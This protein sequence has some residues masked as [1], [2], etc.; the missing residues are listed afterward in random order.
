MLIKSRIYLYVFLIGAVLYSTLEVA[1]RG[2]THW[3]MFL[4]GGVIFLLIYLIN[5]YLR[6]NSLTVRCL[7]S[8][9]IITTGELI[10]GIVVNIVLN[11]N[12][13]DY[14]N[15][16]FNFLGQICLV[17]TAAWFIVSI[18]ACLLSVFIYNKLDKK[19]NTDII[20]H[21]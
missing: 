9:L 16:P 8:T 14:S 20:A 13:W 10:A 12:V 7:L 21:F 2:Y 4:A 15:Q 3:T 1:F 19:H 6:T 17:F 11:M 5:K 18:P